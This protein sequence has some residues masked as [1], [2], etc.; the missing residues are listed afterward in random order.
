[1]LVLYIK[2]AV[3]DWGLMSSLPGTYFQETLV[4]LNQRDLFLL[5]LF[6]FGGGARQLTCF[7]RKL[8][9]PRRGF[10]RH[11]G[12]SSQKIPGILQCQMQAC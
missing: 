5:Q 6:V 7:F 12:A 10:V 11:E 9:M 3:V 8:H 2:T 1:M 4:L